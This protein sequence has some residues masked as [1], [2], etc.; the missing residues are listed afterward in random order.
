MPSGMTLGPL[1]PPRLALCL[2]PCTQAA[3]SSEQAVSQE[4]PGRGCAI[5]LA[6][7]VDQNPRPPRGPVHR[8][9]C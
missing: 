6:Q 9:L 2:L 1:G 4:A 7:E 3:P 8:L 5:P